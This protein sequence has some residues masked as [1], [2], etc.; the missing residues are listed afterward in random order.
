MATPGHFLNRR[1]GTKLYWSLRPAYNQKEK[2]WIR[3]GNVG[4]GATTFGLLLVTV[5]AVLGTRPVHAETN[6]YSTYGM[7]GL[8]DMPTAR[9]APDAELTGTVFHFGK[10]TRTTLSFQVTPRLTAS[11]RYAA[12]EGLGGVRDTLYDRSFDLHYRFLDE[13]RYRP[14]VAVGLRDFIGT[15]V[16]SSE[17]VV[18]TK[19]LSPRVSVTGG[20]GW[21]RLATSGGF[22]N[23]L[24]I[25]SSKFETRPEETSPLGGQ[26]EATNWFR[27]DAA[28]FGGLSWQATDRLKVKLEYSSDAYPQEEARAT[29]DRDGQMNLGLDYRWSDSVSVH[30]FY[31]YGST[32]GAAFNIINNP[33]R[34]VAPSGT[35]SAPIPVRARAPGSGR[36]LGWVSDPDT[37]TSTRSLLKEAMAN[38]GMEVEALSL[39]PHRVRIHV[40]NPRFDATAEAIGRTV[41]ILTQVTPDSV[42]TFVIVPVV[43]GI[44]ASAVTVRRSDAEA[45][46]HAPDGAEQMLA[47]AQVGDAHG[48]RPPSFDTSL[49]PRFLW[50]IGPYVSTSYFDPDEPVR[51]GVGLQVDAEWNAAPGLYFSGSVRHRLAGNIGDSTRVSDSVLP[52]VRSDSNIYDRDGE[53]A[54]TNLTADYYFRPGPDLYGRV[55]AGYLEPQYGGLSSE[56]LWKPV[57]SAVALGAEINYARQRDFD[58]AFGFREYDVVTGH[59]S[60]YWDLPSDFHVQ[61]DAGRYLAGDWGATFAVDREFDNGWRVGAYATFTDVSFDDFGEGSFDKGLRFTIPLSPLIGMP[62]RRQYS[63]RIQPLTRDGGARLHVDGRLYETVREYHAGGLERSWG[64]FWR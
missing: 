57:Q 22:T 60:G 29:I 63:A 38:E 6:S 18:A 49:Y 3:V 7:P 40:R 61:V 41:R 53:T 10:T 45:L 4:R 1:D 47:R 2:K 64:R 14:A 12:L 54:L 9:T 37:T 17:Y 8:I 48:G 42:E 23:P 34:S 21:G 33:K 59:A 35:H 32:F 46:E 28:L 58:Q 39:E 20:I 44:P 27:G 15:G 36:D 43:K 13:G 52:R 51:F 16:Y 24:G 30:A 19:S 55:S 56:L 26:L 5:P 62:T 50:G 25:L 11:F 31:M